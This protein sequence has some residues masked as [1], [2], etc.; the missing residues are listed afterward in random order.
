MR[1]GHSLPISCSPICSSVPCI[2]LA[3]ALARHIPQHGRAILSGLT[4]AQARGIEARFAAHGFILEKRIVLE[5][6]T[7]LVIVRRKESALRD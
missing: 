4:D 2:K 6:W 3:P 7:T 5:G 1:S